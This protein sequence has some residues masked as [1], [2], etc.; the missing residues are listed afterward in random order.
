MNTRLHQAFEHEWSQARAARLAGRLDQA[1][2][3]LERAH[4]LGQSFTKRHVKSHLG[5]LHVGWLQS[6]A[7]EVIGQVTRIVAASLFTRIWVPVGNTGGANVS[8]IRPMPVPEVLQ[9]LLDEAK[10]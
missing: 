5:M 8:A 10:A 6:D 1:F 4:I 7:R 3:H 2:A 9:A